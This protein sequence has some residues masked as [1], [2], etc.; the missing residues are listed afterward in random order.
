MQRKLEAGAFLVPAI[1][2]CGCSLIQEFSRAPR[3]AV[4]QLLLTKAIEHAPHS[5]HNPTIFLLEQTSLRVDVTGL[6]A[7]SDTLHC[8]LL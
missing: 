6:Q 2:F 8:E 1:L 5:L 7:M 3:T 4:E